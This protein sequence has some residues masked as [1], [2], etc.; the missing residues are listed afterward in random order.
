M[1]VRPIDSGQ[2]ILGGTH[3]FSGTRLPLLIS[4]EHLDPVDQLDAVLDD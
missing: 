1:T 4:M 2:E 3:V